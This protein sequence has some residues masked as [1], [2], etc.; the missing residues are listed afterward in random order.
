MVIAR[1]SPL[2]L[3]VFL[4]TVSFSNLGLAYF[5]DTNNMN[6]AVSWVDIES[7]QVVLKRTYNSRSLYQ[8]LFGFGWCS[9]LETI[10]QIDRAED[11]D[12]PIR[13]IICGAGTEIEFDSRGNG[14]SAS[15]AHCPDITYEVSKVQDGWRVSANDGEVYDFSEDGYLVGGVAKNDQEGGL[16]EFSID[17]QFGKPNRVSYSS[18]ADIFFRFNYG[19]F[20]SEVESD[21]VLLQYEYR[22]GDLVSVTEKTGRA[23]HYAY[24]DLHNLVSITFPDETQIS[25]T[26]NV[27]KDW[28][29]TATNRNGC[30]ETYS[31]QAFSRIRYTTSLRGL[32]DGRIVSSR[33]YFTGFSSASAGNQNISVV[34]RQDNVE[35][36][37]RE[38]ISPEW[39]DGRGSLLIVSGSER[40]LWFEK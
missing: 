1:R 24:D 18:G 3:V 31:A 26:Y 16:L 36:Y 20:V 30:V 11:V 7:D 32:C 39:Q 35:V 2:A 27:W 40:R 13:M 28:I 23:H 21:D 14:F 37:L 22:N 29:A 8:G 6:L 4:F 25:F 5:V 9:T 17:Y 38:T 15:C 19:G 10:L 34:A 12:V 33:Q